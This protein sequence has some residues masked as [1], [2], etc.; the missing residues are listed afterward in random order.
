MSNT[1]ANCG[2]PI[3]MGIYCAAHRFG[4]GSDRV[5]PRDPAERDALINSVANNPPADEASGE[6]RETPH[7][8]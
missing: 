1:C 6:N 2:I 5:V 8:W 7:A 4:D 3:S